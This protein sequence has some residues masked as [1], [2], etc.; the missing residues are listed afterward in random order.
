MYELS[1]V[2][3]LFFGT[4][5]IAVPSLLALKEVAEIVGVVCQPDRP[6]GRGMRLRAPAVKEA[7]EALGLAV[8]QPEKVR[9]G[10]LEAWVREKNADVA[11]VI[12]YGRILPLSLLSAPR[13]GSVNLHAS[14]LPHYR[15]AAPIQRALMNGERETG[16]CLMQMDEGMDTGPVLACHR[17]EIFPSDNAGSLAERLGLLAAEVTRIELPRLAR[18]LLVPTPQAPEGATY[19]TPITREDAFLDFNQKTAREL[20]HQIRGLAPRP[21]AVSRVSSGARP[22]LRVIEARPV[23]R[24]FELSPGEVGIDGARI[25]VGTSGDELLEIEQAQLEGKRVQSARDLVNGR[26]LK[27]GDRLEIPSAS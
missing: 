12:A 25:L 22:Q 19:A 6:A 2:R 18:G 20:T 7:A 21:G 5:E 23:A 26:A 9:N 15:G 27:A 10:E 4:P 3:A 14:L 13:L 11:L 1:L 24:L 17:I 16:V 8:H